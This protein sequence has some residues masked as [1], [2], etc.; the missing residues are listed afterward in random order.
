MKSEE[1]LNQVFQTAHEHLNPGGVFL[2][3]VEESSE[4]FKQNRTISSTHA[5]G[6]IQITFIENSYD[7]NPEDNHFEMTF[8]YLVREKG[9]LEIFTDSHIWGAFNMETWRRLLKKAGFSFQEL[10]FEHPTF[11]EDEFLPMFVCL[12]SQ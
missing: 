8:I 6:G 1:E 12:K 11:L 10:D 3:V 9:V 2:T 5:Q 7:P 4:H